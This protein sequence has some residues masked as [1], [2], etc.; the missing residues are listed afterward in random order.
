MYHLSGAPRE[1]KQLR[2]AMGLLGTEAPS[3]E[4]YSSD[5]LVRALYYACRHPQMLSI[6]AS[7]SI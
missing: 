6:Y 5:V 1:N 7:N 2:F 4:A 3:L